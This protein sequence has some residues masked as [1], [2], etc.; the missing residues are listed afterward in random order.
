MNRYDSTPHLFLVD[1]EDAATAIVKVEHFFATTMLVKYDEVQIDRQ[2]TRSA[3]Q[4]EFF[5]QMEHGLSRNHAQ[6]CALL[7]ELNEASYGD[8][9][10]WR[11]MPQGYLSKTV[12]TLAHLLDGFFGIDSALYN[13]VDDSHLVDAR[14]MQ[15]I[16]SMPHNYWLISAMGISRLGDVDRVPFLRR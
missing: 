11:T 12:H 13:L 9:R 8:L 6:L 2:A 7:D 10:S 15:Q 16:R 14:R 3:T 1:G 4:T 5:T